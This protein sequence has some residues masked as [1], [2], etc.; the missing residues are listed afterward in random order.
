MIDNKRGP[1]ISSQFCFVDEKNG[2]Y[3]H[4]RIL[5]GLNDHYH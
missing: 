5:A 4:E 3:Y 1:T 2:A